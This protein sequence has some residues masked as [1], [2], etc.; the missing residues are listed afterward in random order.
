MLVLSLGGCH[1]TATQADA[2]TGCPVPHALAW[3]VEECGPT[4]L[5]SC[6]FS[7]SWDVCRESPGEAYGGFTCCICDLS[8]WRSSAQHCDFFY[9]SGYP[10]PADDAGPDADTDAG[11]SDALGD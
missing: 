9:D 8:T 1:G 2:G 11:P 3:E 5:C 7:C 10:P 4:G 6:R